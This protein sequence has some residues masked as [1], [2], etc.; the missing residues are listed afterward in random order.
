MEFSGENIDR[1][2]DTIVKGQT[3]DLHSPPEV[4]LVEGSLEPC[5]IVIFGVTGDLIPFRHSTSNLQI[6]KVRH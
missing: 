1:Y 3:S 4:C 6:G 5:T 2:I